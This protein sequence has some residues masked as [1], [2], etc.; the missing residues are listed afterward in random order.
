MNFRQI[1]EQ[2]KGQLQQTEEMLSAVYTELDRLDAEKIDI[3]EAQ[4]TI[5]EVAEETQ[6]EL[7]FHISALVSMALAS[8]F[9]DPYQLQIEFTQKRNQTEAELSFMRGNNKVDDPLN[10]AGGGAC[11]VAAFGLRIAMWTLKRPHTR[12]I[13]VLDEPFPRLKGAQANLRALQ[14]VKRISDE[15]G[16]QV[17]MISDERV[18]MEDIEAAADNVIK[19]AIK[20]GVSYVA[21]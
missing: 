5:M 3:E 13:M 18:P 15:L 8:V 2:R 17:L 6:R 19:I 12:P 10:G 11:D 21:P 16:I 4:T 7:E 9:D 20:G 1:L 14:M